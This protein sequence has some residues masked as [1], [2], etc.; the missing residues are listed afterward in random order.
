[1]NIKYLVLKIY[2]FSVRVIF[3]TQSKEDETV[4]IDKFFG[5]YHNWIIVKNHHNLLGNI[6]LQNYTNILKLKTNSVTISILVHMYY[7]SRF[8]Y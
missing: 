4:G 5:S 1:M 6:L 3:Y 7:R 2:F 8:K